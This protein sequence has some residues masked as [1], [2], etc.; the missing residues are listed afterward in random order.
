M[1]SILQGY[2]MTKREDQVLADLMHKKQT[3]NI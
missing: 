2:I 3:N 1:G